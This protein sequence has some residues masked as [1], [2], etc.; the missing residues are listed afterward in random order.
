[1]VLVISDANLPIDIYTDASFKSIGAKFQKN[2]KIEKRD[3][4]LKKN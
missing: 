4:F 3:I 2:L 1:M